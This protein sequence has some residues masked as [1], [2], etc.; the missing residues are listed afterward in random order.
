MKISNFEGVLQRAAKT[1]SI[2]VS[3]TICTAESANAD[4][5]TWLYYS[6]S[7]VDAGTTRLTTF[8]DPLSLAS[9]GTFKRQIT[10][11]TEYTGGYQSAMTW[12]ESEVAEIMFDCLDSRMRYSSITWYEWAQ[13]QGRVT[14]VYSDLPWHPIARVQM[15]L[16]AEVCG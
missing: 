10:I 13:A 6:G 2:C 9:F 11:L 4:E 1:V 5:Y 12:G 15:D 7:P 8:I 16:F 3:L 14:K